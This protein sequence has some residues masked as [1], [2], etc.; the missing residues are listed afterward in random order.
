MALRFTIF[1]RGKLRAWQ[2]TEWP[3]WRVRCS[4]MCRR[5]GF[6]QLPVPTGEPCFKGTVIVP[7]KLLQAMAYALRASIG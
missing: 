6:L 5:P 4:S 3:R 2:M 1:R 7:R